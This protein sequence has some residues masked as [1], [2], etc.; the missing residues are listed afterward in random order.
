M[1]KGTTEL[2]AF[3]LRPLMFRE[4]R[5]LIALFNSGL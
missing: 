5:E 1:F 3:L 4:T 2:I